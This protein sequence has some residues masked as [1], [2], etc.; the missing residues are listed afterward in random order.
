MGI[1]NSVTIADQEYDSFLRVISPLT[2]KIIVQDQWDNVDGQ[3]IKEIKD[4]V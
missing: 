4:K 2:G 3:E 1:L